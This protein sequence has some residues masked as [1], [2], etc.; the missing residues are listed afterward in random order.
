MSR[1]WVMTD[2]VKQI[3]RDKYAT[4]ASIAE[5]AVECRCSVASISKFAQSESLRR[6]RGN[7][8]G[9]GYCKITPEQAKQIVLVYERGL[10]CRVIGEHFG[11][12]HQG[13][14]N[15]VRKEGG[16]VRSREHHRKSVAEILAEVC[17]A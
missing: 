7:R 11:L 2:S 10:N 14:L 5:L 3:V 6:K 17:A 9:G 12:S 15:V 8:N 16:K 1:A 4:V 13:V